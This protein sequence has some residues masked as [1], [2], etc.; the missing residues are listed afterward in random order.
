MEERC[1]TNNCSFAGVKPV[2][3]DLPYPEIKVRRKNRNYA[4]LLNVDYC[5]FVSELS[6][7]T[8]YIN[9]ENRISFEE[10]AM[11]RTLLGIA[12]AEMMHL[13]K[14]GELI[15]LLGGN[16]DFS[17]K[18]CNGR[19]KLWSPEYLT[20]PENIDKMLTADIE[21]EKDAIR[22][23]EMHIKMIDDDC[24]NAVLRRIIL[25]EE[26]HIMLLKSLR[27]GT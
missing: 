24:V 4:D 9:N 3:V 27:S 7:I 14:L 15:V 12:I 26:Y 1:L 22:Q 17:C 20:I 5:G 23:Y 19:P 25:D 16:V 18:T 21:A 8:Q 11:A 2:M 13:Q 10:C 6:A